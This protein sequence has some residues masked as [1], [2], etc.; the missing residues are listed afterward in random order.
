MEQDKSASICR[1]IFFCNDLQ[2]IY[3]IPY[4]LNCPILYYWM[5]YPTGLYCTLLEED[6]GKR[7]IHSTL[8]CLNE[9][10]AKVNC[11]R[12]TDWVIYRSRVCSDLIESAAIHLHGSEKPSHP[13]PSQPETLDAQLACGGNCEMWPGGHVL[14]LGY[15]FHCYGCYCVIQHIHEYCIAKS[16]AM[17]LVFAAL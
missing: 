10:L 15:I 8:L 1:E 3:Y 11:V 7:N 17:R 12:L 2:T 16:F 9:L 13:K 4:V 14:Y 5:L 6:S